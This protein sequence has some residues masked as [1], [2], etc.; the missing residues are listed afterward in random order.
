ML[1]EAD[2]VT[3]LATYEQL[4]PYLTTSPLTGKASTETVARALTILRL[5]GWLSLTSKR[6][7]DKG[8]IQGNVYL[9]HDEPL[10]IYER[11][12]TDADYLIL[13]SNA[14]THQS[15]TIQKVA[16]YTLNEL[17]N[18]PHVAERKLPTRLEVLTERLRQYEAG[19]KKLST[20]S[21]TKDGDKD[22]LRNNK[23]PYTKSK[24]SLKSCDSNSLRHRKYISSSKDKN[25]LLQ[26]LRDNLKLP[27][28]FLALS[29]AQQ[30]SGL[31]ALSTLEP[32]QQQQVLD[33]WQQRCEQQAIRNPAAYLHGIIQKALQGEL[34]LL[35]SSQHSVS[36]Q[37]PSNIKSGSIESK[38]LQSKLRTSECIATPAP[39][40]SCAKP[41]DRIQAQHYLKEIKQMLK[42][43]SHTKS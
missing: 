42:N 6:R 4:Q 5:T 40:V 7:H 28:R 22:L 24:A 32:V 10:S 11:L 35:R 20:T 36:T 12:Q 38:L 30:D 21:N 41:T 15:K 1:L 26:G 8:M 17:I 27:A 31:L 18:D 23:Q 13:L 16:E 43:A 14:T 3:S 33:E 29:T 2:G 39:V 25:I 19:A 34:N 37:S 9:L